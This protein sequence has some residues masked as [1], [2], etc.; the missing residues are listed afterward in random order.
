MARLTPSPKQEE[1]LQHI[2]Q[3]IQEK[4]YSPTD[5]VFIQRALSMQ[6]I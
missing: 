1:T 5:T 6:R 3:F 4:G 2:R